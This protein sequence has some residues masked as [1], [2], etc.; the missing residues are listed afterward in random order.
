MPASSAWTATPLRAAPRGGG[1]AHAPSAR[2][3]A[4][5]PRSS[6]NACSAANVGY[7]SAAA[8]AISALGGMRASAC[9]RALMLDNTAVAHA[10]RAVARNSASNQGVLLLHTPKYLPTSSVLDLSWLAVVSA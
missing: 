10:D 7:N 8:P 6:I 9:V 4:G 1:L 3:P 2:P 5:L